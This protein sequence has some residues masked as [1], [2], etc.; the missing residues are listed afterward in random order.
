MEQQLD[1]FTI[2]RIELMIDMA[3]KKLQQQVDSMKESMCSMAGE[4]NSLKSQINRMQ[5]QPQQA[6]V[7]QT[8]LSDSQS[9]QGAKPRK[10]V[11]IV[12][13]RPENEKKED[14]QSGAAKNA[15]PVRPRYGDYESKD[16]SIDKFFYFGRK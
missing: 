3:T 1:V 14:F 9:Q 13:C 10:E 16:V 2:K 11:E 7:V 4:I 15:E 5:F 6:R 12:D 8:T